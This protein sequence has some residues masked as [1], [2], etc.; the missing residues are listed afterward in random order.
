MFGCKVL[1][2]FN[3]IASFVYLFFNYYGGSSNALVSTD[4]IDTAASGSFLGL[5]PII[6]IAII[7]SIYYVTIL[8]SIRK[9]TESLHKQRQ[10][11]KLNLYQNLFKIILDQ[12]Y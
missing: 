9:T 4:S 12:L 5:L 1:A 11:I 7:L 8:A 2:G 10:I 6:P 3:F